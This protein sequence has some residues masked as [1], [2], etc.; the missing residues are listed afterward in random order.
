M[1]LLDRQHVDGEGREPV[2]TRVI[3]ARDVFEPRFRVLRGRRN[4]HLPRRILA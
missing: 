1:P 2:F 3:A 4:Q